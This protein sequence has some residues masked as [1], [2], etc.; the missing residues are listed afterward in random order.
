MKNWWRLLSDPTTSHE[1][2]K[3]EL[4]RV[5][6]PSTLRD[7]QQMVNGKS[8]SFI[9]LIDNK[10]TRNKVKNVR[11]GIGFEHNY[12]ISNKGLSGGLAFQ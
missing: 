4:P 8:P 3:L 6:K 10:C 1:L 5:G 12:V 11:N 2:L 7:L 9:F